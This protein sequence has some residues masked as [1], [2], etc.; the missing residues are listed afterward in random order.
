MFPGIYEIQ[1]VKAWQKQNTA[2]YL[3]APSAMCWGDVSA[4]Q[5]PLYPGATYEWSS[6]GGLHVEDNGRDYSCNEAPGILAS[7]KITALSGGSGTQTLTLKITFP[8]G[9]VE[10]KTIIIWVFPEIP[11]PP[12]YVLT[13]YPGVGFGCGYTL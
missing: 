1:Y 9:Y 7:A 5:A 3:K 2:I 13:H 10:T 11:A 4:C 6:S 8:S 12:T